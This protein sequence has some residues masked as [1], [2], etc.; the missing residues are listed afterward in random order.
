MLINPYCR[1][2]GWLFEDFK[3]G[4]DAVEIPGVEVRSSEAP[5]PEADAWIC[6]RTDEAGACPDPSRCVVQVHDFREHR[7]S[8]HTGAISYV[9]PRQATT[10]PR[11]HGSTL[12]TC[13]PIGARRLFTLRDSMPE[14]FTVGWVGRDVVYQ[15]R[16]IKRPQ[17]FVNAVKA[18]RAAGVEVDAA[19]YGPGLERYAS[20]LGGVLMARKDFDGSLVVSGDGCTL[21]PDGDRAAS[22]RAFYHSID[23]L[24]VTCEP[25]PGP[26]SIY[27]A[28]ACGVPVISTGAGAADVVLDRMRQRWRLLYPDDE[29]PKYTAPED[30]DELAR[31]IGIASR[32]RRSMFYYHREDIRASVTHWQDGPGGWLEENVRLAME[33]AG[34]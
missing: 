12:T 26:L 25:E 8:I 19:L 28:L 3:A 5:I 23:A 15:G 11:P 10:A 24:I 17:L 16:D 2:W 9:H 18:A 34:G 22:L 32:D 31:R 6:I 27:E 14:R 30:A 7:F 20:Q 29:H 33:V 13:R 1:N 21:Y 4:F